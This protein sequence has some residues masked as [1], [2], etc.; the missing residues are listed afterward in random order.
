MVLESQE[1]IT[2]L[3]L[4]LTFFITELQSQ[5]IKANSESN[6]ITTE[7]IASKLKSADEMSHIL[8]FIRKRMTKCIQSKHL[9][10][11]YP[12]STK[13]E[14]FKKLKTISARG[15]LTQSGPWFL[16]KQDK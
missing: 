10:E 13:S 1:I 2:S 15:Y 5:N 6:E 7:N 14:C 3:K 12:K 16:L 9:L 4:Y 8:D 11:L